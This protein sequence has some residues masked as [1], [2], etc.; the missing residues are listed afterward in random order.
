MTPS[1]INRAMAEL[2]GWKTTKRVCGCYEPIMQHA[3][4]RELCLCPGQLDYTTDLNAVAQVEARLTTEDEL[5]DYMDKL[6][7]VLTDKT[8]RKYLVYRF[9]LH[10]LSLYGIIRVCIASPIQRCEALLRAHGKWEE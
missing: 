1:Q 5:Y 2:D 9:G 7:Y 4:G 10:C 3:D 8:H 6:A